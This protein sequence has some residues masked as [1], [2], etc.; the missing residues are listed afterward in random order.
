MG[1]L[2]EVVLASTL[3]FAGIGCVGQDSATEEISRR[4]A[5]A[6]SQQSA[7]KHSGTVLASLSLGEQQVLEF[8]EFKPGVTGTI[9]TG[10]VF[11]APKVTAELKKMNS[12]DLYRHLAGK[13]AKVPDALAAAVARA[14]AMAQIP[15]DDMTPPPAPPAEEGKVTAGEGPHFY[16]DAEQVWFRDTF[17]NGA[18]GCSQGWDWANVTSFKAISTGAGYY[19]AGSEAANAVAN[20]MSDWYS[21]AWHLFWRAYTLPG[22]WRSIGVTSPNRYIWWALSGAGNATVSVAATYP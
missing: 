14:E 8:V 11:S 5:E 13:S 3:V 21:G 9:E 7:Q 15:V 22:W 10:P 12:I 4:S 16:N 2:T 18:Q 20:D 17:C 1:H 6:L 19:M